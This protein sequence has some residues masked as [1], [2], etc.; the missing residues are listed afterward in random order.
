MMDPAHRMV[1]LTS[2]WQF[3][4]WI[5]ISPHAHSYLSF[6]PH[7]VMS[8]LVF[9]AC[10]SMLHQHPQNSSCCAQGILRY[11]IIIRDHAIHYDRGC[12]RD[13]GASQV[14]VELHIFMN[15]IRP[16]SCCAT[17]VRSPGIVR[18]LRCRTIPAHCLLARLRHGM[19]P[20]SRQD[21]V[22]DEHLL[23]LGPPY[24]RFADQ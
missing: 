23:R 5:K 17:R 19:A 12:Q 21:S 24:I 7:P 11:R 6:L 13:P 14:R 2:F 8:R 15:G 18:Q 16:G 20:E 4:P 3:P 22:A 10:L 1:S 9:G